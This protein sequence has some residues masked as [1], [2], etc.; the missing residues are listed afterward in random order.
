MP[1]GPRLA[2]ALALLA[3]S[4]ARAD[5]PAAVPA[6]RSKPPA[7]RGVRGGPAPGP[8]PDL[9]RPARRRL[10]PDRRRRPPGPGQ[11]QRDLAPG[12]GPLG[13]RRRSSASPPRGRPVQGGAGGRAGRRARPVPA[14]RPRRV[15]ARATGMDVYYIHKFAVNGVYLGDRMAFVQ[16]TARLRPVPGGI[17]EPLP[18]VTAHE[19]G[20]ALGLPHRQDRTNLLASGTTGTTLNEAEVAR[21]REKARSIPRRA[22]RARPPQE[23]RGGRRPGRRRR[24]PPPPGLARRGSPARG[25]R[26]S[27]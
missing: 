21:S 27:R 6:A 9:D 25:R 26:R 2:L 8:R 16:E 10:R 24:G 7:V 19:L 14:A 20:H 22:R 5:D 13:P 1:L 4:P 18:R 23:G 17:D 12:R 3:G 11:G 15:A